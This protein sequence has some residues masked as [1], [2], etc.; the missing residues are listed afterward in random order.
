MKPTDEDILKELSPDRNFAVNAKVVLK[1]LRKAGFDWNDCRI[2]SESG[3]VK[4]LGG[5]LGNMKKVEVIMPMRG[6]KLYYKKEW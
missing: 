6:S 3:K 1:R 2:K 5:H 4:A